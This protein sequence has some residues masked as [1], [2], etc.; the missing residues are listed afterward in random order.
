M[1]GD[2]PGLRQP[3]G[4][5]A[6]IDPQFRPKLHLCDHCGTTAD[7]LPMERFLSAAIG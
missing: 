3:S 5:V 1:G 2:A 4:I 7:N 6:G